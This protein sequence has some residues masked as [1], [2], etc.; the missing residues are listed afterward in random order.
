MSFK[1]IILLKTIKDGFSVGDMVARQRFHLFKL[2]TLFTVIVYLVFLYQVSLVEVID[3]IV[4]LI[5]SGLIVAVCVNHLLLGWHKNQ[6]V[7]NIVLLVVLFVLLHIVAYFSGGLRNSTML[8]IAPLIL[9]SYMLLGRR[10]GLLMAGIAICHAAYFYWVSSNTKWITYDLLGNDEAVVNFD[11]FVTTIL[12]VCMIAIQARYAEKNNNEA[13]AD[14]KQK[15]NAYREVSRRLQLATKGANIGIWDYDIINKQL[16]WDDIMYAIFGIGPDDFNNTVDGWMALIYPDDREAILDE[17]N[18][19]L[20]G[21]KDFNTS[22]RIVWPDGS[23]RHIKAR[24]IINRNSKGEAIR[25]VGTN[26][27]IT[28][29][30]QNEVHIK[31]LNDSLE[32]KIEVRT[33][34]LL[35]KTQQL[36]EAQQLA[37][38]GNWNIDKIKEEIYWSKGTRLIYGVNDAFVP[39]YDAFVMML[40]PAD[41]DRVIEKKKVHQLTGELLQD[42]YR[43]IRPDGCVRTVYSQTQF[44]FNKNGALVRIYGTIQDI[45]ERKKSEE[46][47]RRSEANLQAIFDN[48]RAGYILL[49]SELNVLL[50]NNEAASCVKNSLNNT[51]TVGDNWLTYFSGEGLSEMNERILTV[52]SNKDVIYQTSYLQADGAMTYFD[53]LM[54]P[55]SKNKEEIFGICI[56]INDITL[57]KLSEMGTL[58]YVEQ[59]QVKNKNLKQFAYMVSHNLRSPI[60][61]IQ[62]LANLLESD[63]EGDSENEKILKYITLEINNL[64]NVIKDMNDIIT[65]TDNEGMKYE[66]VDFA[67]ELGLIQSVLDE[68]ITES[69]AEIRSDFKA[70]AGTVTVKGYI[71]S[72]IYNLVSNAIKYRSPDRQPNIHI[73]TSI[74][75]KFICFSIKDNG[76]GIDMEKNG[77]KIFELYKRLHGKTIPGKGIGLSMVKI[78]VEAMGGKIEVESHLNEGSTFKVCLPHVKVD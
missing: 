57:K 68:A 18:K 23:M 78:Q 38:I 59:L 33:G 29:Q 35:D 46:T 60:V 26:W 43:I 13:I 9:L 72:I 42:E 12:S 7:A 21:E 27:D 2:A 51:I 1:K 19:A 47:L 10:G 62:G 63:K 39:G 5:L 30:I 69:R 24:G 74:C 66:Y 22:Y 67:T 15:S 25:M 34:E 37:K 11:Y 73:S 20:S 65:A 55:V 32:L 16:M 49:D 70:S 71:Y 54:N 4:F 75:S 77:A 8:Y 58:E 45:T 36:D 53:I 41:R 76:M 40:H 50:F 61:K 31:E 3:T 17:A 44:L 64:D 52:L 6:K 28:S 48:A 56:A 14:I